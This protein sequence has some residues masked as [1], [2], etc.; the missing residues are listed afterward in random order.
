MNGSFAHLRVSS[1]Y[2][3]FKGLLSI[4][5]L[6]EKAKS[7]DMP[8]IALTDHSNMFGL[9]KFFKKCEKEGIK[10]IS[11]STLN[12]ARSQEDRPYEFLCLAKNID[13]HKN[14]MHGLS[15]ASRNQSKAIFY[16]D[17]LNIC[18]D[19]FVIAGSENSEIFSLILN[20][21]ED[22]AVKL[23]EK[24]KLDFKNNF[25]I[26]IQNTGKESHKI[27]MASILPIASR[28]SIPV[29]ATND[30]LFGDREDFEI[31]ETKVCINSGKTLNDPNREKIYSEEQYFKSQDEMQDLFKDF[32][33][34]L[35]NT[36][37]IAKQCNL[38]LEPDGYFLP[39]YPVP[40]GQDFDSHLKSLVEENLNNLTTKFA[41][42]QIE[43]YKARV[44]YELDQIKT[45]GFSSYFLIVY[46]FIKWSKNNDVPVGP[47][48]GS[49]AGSLVAYCLGITALDPIKHG[50]LFERFLNPER[51]SMPDFD[52][53]FC[54]EKRDK[55][56]EYVSSKYG[57]D[58]V[59]QIVTF[60]TMA[61]KG[62]VRDVTRALGKPYSLGD[63]ISKMIPF[64]IG[65]T[66]E[67]A[68]SRQ[69]VLKQAIKDDDE[70][71]EIMNLS[72]KLEGGIRNIGK[73]AGGVVIAPGS[74]SDFSP[75]Y[76][77]SDTS[78]VLTQFDKDDVEKIGLVK[79]DFLGLR[80][81]T[82]I[83]KAIKSINDDLASKNEDPLDISNLDL[84]DSKVFEL[85]SA[86][87]TTAVFQLESPG[88][89]D[90]IKRLQPT[91]FEE[92]VALL[93][94]FRPGPLDSGMH[95][96][97]VNR[98][99][100]K[101]PVTYPHK[102]LE[103]VLSETYGVILYQEQVMES[104]RVLAGY[105]L[106]QADILRR[107]MGKKQVEEMDKQRTIFVDGCKDN[108]IKEDLAN[109]IFNLIETF[110]GYGFNKS[111][112]AAYALLSF[113][114]AYLKTYY[115]EY[116]M[117]AVL[118]SAQ[119][120]TD[121]IS[122]I[123][124]ECKGM[125]INVLSPN[126]LTS[127]TNFFVNP[128]K[129]IEYGLTSLKGVAESFIYHLSEIREKNTF[130]NLLDFSKKVNVKLG[131][132]KSLESLS[133]AGAFDSICDSRSIALA[134]IP[135]M[136]KEGDKK[137]S[138]A[139]FAGDLFSNVEE[140]FNPYDQYKDVNPLNFSQKL[141]YEKEAL[142]FYISGHPVEAIQDDI[143]DLRSHKISDL[144]ANTS[145]AT[146]VGLVNSTRQI[147]DSK[148][149]PIT[150]LN[151]DDESGSMDGIIL[152]ELYEEKY[153][154]IKEGT[155]LRFHGSVEVDDYRSRETNSTMY[156]M[157]VKNINAV[158]S[159]LVDSKKDLL[160]ICDTVNGDSLQEIK[161]KLNKIDSD[162]W[163]GE[164]KVKLKILKD[165]TE[166]LISLN[167]N[168]MIDLNSENL[169]NLRSIF[170]DNKI[171]LS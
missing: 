59:S 163:G 109:K 102:L 37:E 54:M 66:L 151:F 138:D 152:S 123:I 153:G 115:P 121:K 8:A 169:D 149:K 47:G 104:A 136:L 76:F 134:C 94:L 146:I 91:K 142:G 44:K 68:I 124:K 106:G 33:E 87:K 32:P 135:D 127:G 112:S 143:K 29:I 48:R 122:S 20:D 110:A 2:S 129:Q 11:G 39:E 13:G 14:L 78:S 7:F 90:L 25:V 43:E 24:Y 30:V 77:D 114:T 132:K 62:V 141:K 162:F 21:K 38:S 10:P 133:K 67:K 17:F 69:P 86:G 12:I 107:A 52:I 50:L 71:Q 3:I 96:E 5:K 93:A 16:D 61:A 75:I 15:K 161:L 70:V 108:N 45:M 165:S 74:L 105:S 55:V 36:L 120:N 100:G 147:K 18:N 168:F 103:P 84:N 88:M 156:R 116:F 9:V 46:D 56:I 27:F 34:V 53:D 139:L 130:T 159:D 26:E 140:D 63:R 155:I 125:G 160:I 83:D 58:A 22:E 49:G 171:K 1:E 23:I 99:N 157:R 73:H 89:K 41:K 131:G 119:G 97:F 72:F 51:I 81:L 128:K 19:I 170:G 4:E 60:G 117:A 126:I 101:V 148:N 164:S 40:E 6:V 92:I 154:I 145:S 167:D 144:D 166:A 80:T 98:K 113:Q 35:S 95:D 137:A 85:L 111:H 57:K 118:S 64:E 150:F 28:L 79:F 31:H 65:M 158:E 82:I 42:D